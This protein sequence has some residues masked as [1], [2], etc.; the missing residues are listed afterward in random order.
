MLTVYLLEMKL[1][2]V[3]LLQKLFVTVA[4]VFA[5]GETVGDC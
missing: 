4:C 1:L 5:A 2:T 3:Y